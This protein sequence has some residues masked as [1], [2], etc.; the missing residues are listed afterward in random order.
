[1]SRKSVPC[2]VERRCLSQVSDIMGRQ[3]ALRAR[4]K[5][6]TA[7]LLGLMACSLQFFAQGLL[8]RERN[9]NK[10]TVMKG[11]TP[12]YADGVESVRSDGGHFRVAA[13]GRE[14]P[15]RAAR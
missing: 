15:P 12:T 10:E 4:R 14:E 9:A 6:L 5:Y 2:A 13:Q 1:M 8:W 11:L 3:I 7:Q